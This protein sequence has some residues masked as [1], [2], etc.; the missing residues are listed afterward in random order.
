VGDLVFDRARQLVATK[1]IEAGIGLYQSQGQ[2]W[3]E[4]ALASRQQHYLIL[5][6]IAFAAGGEK[7]GPGLAL[8]EMPQHGTFPAAAEDQV[9]DQG[10][11]S[12]ENH[13]HVSAGS[14]VRP[15]RFQEL[16]HLHIQ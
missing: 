8:T 7:S 10:R 16:L 12:Y 15:Q 14:A 9:N 11:Q 13:D 2:V 3:I 6:Q 1:V 5:E 4:R